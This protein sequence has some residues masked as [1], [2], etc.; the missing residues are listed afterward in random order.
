LPDEDVGLVDPLPGEL[1]APP[2][3]GI[4]LGGS[5]DVLPENVL[6]GEAAVN[7]AA[8]RS[9]DGH[10]TGLARIWPFLGPAFIA[11]VAYI[12]P[13]NFATNIA[14]GAKF[15]YLLLWVV[16]GAN[17][18]AMVVQTQSAKLGIA[19]GR[20]L[21]EACRDA[22]SRRTSIGLWIQAE[23]VA[24]ACDV[25]E[26]VGAA[27]GLNLL[28]GIPLFPAGLL[29]GLGAFAI[30]ALQQRG[31]RRLEAVIA[32]MV[33]VVV[34]AFA[35]EVISSSPDGGEVSKHL[36][37]PAFS[38]TE[39]ILLATGIIGATVMPHVIYLH[40]ALTQR[41]IV[42]R[43]NEERR[44][45]L[46]FEKI[47][48]VIA[49]AL[50]GA[51]NLSM[52]IMAAALFH[53]SG[54]VNIDTIDGAFDGLKHLVSPGAATVFGIALLASGY[55]SSSV[56][57]MSG[58]VVMQGFIRR[59]IPLFL[60]RAITL[61]PA[62]IVLAIGLDPTDALV[63]SQVVLSFGIPFALVP[64]VILGQRRELMGALTNPAWLTVIVSI[65]SGLI[66][67]LNVFLLEQVF[68]G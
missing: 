26:V 31:F 23:I 36:F 59:R 65:L 67:A 10:A 66:I 55:A 53:T 38:G 34:A 3:P 6:P 2:G 28:F 13:G 68:I 12:D 15:G 58:Q 25:A 56:G 20:N 14:G 62:L 60:R 46:R 5:E 37:T 24:A 49:M 33:G 40:S 41:R 47:D 39:S 11:A 50:A 19:T 54:L 44:K 21:A 43:D 42:G 30:L 64:L 51:V 18:I 27:L 16:L 1:S 29:A 17:L 9:L 48:V 57:T 22:F 63:G 4:G 35:F 7:R 45:I 61:A 52:M 32:G 8:R